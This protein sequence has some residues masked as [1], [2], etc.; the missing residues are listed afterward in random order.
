MGLALNEITAEGL[1]DL[2]IALRGMT[3]LQRLNLRENELE[4]RGMLVLAPALAGL[5]ALR[6][7]DLCGNQI[8][9]AGAVKVRPLQYFAM[10]S[11]SSYTNNVRATRVGSIL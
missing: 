11:S 1:G 7:L 3:A 6:E 8:R 9:R 2:C 5:S 10:C 4:D